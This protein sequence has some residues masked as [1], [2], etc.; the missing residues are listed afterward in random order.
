D[1]LGEGIMEL[2]EIVSSPFPGKSIV[3][4]RCRALYDRRLMRGETMESVLDSFRAALADLSDWSVEFATA[5]VECYTG[6]V[7][8]M[9]DFH[10]GWAIDTRGD[11]YARAARGLRAARL[12]PEPFVA[13]YCTNGSYSAGRAGIPTIIFGPS[14]IELAHRI[15]EY[16]EVEELLRGAEGFA[17]LARELAR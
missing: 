9:L 17:G 5:R 10:P 14:T 16:I 3:P 11:W 2:A 6:Q 4:D 7:L 13:P 1:V 8:E 12:E 15:D